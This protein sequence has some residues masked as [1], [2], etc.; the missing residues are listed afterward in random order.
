MTT[1]QSRKKN[2]RIIPLDGNRLGLVTGAVV[3]T[4]VLALGL[5][6]H[7]A[8]LYAIVTRVGWS[9]VLAYGVT[10]LLVFAIIQTRRMEWS[11]IEGGRTEAAEATEEE[12]APEDEEAPAESE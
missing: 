7:E 11:Q 12:E 6:V 2:R 5:F 8:G 10:F 9:F 1:A 3:S 4:V